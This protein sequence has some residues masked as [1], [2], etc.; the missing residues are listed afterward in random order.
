[1]FCVDGVRNGEAGLRGQGL[2]L[3]KI[4]RVIV[5][6]HLGVVLHRLLGSRF[7]REL[8][9]VRLNHVSLC[10]NIKEF[11]VAHRRRLLS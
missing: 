8:A 5:H 11:L 1:V 6:Q 3:A 10:G 7:L 9:Q 2:Q 4:L